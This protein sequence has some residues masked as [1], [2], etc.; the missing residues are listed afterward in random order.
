MTGSIPLNP[1]ADDLRELLSERYNF[2]ISWTDLAIVFSNGL[3]G[4]VDGPARQL[5]TIRDPSSSIV[6]LP[7]TSISN[8]TQAA[9]TINEV[10]TIPV[11]STITI[12]NLIQNGWTTLNNSSINV[13]SS[14]ISGD[15]TL[16]TINFDTSSFPA[17]G[18][19]PNAILLFYS[20]IT[21]VKN[22]CKML[23][24][25][26]DNNLLANEEWL[27]I[28]E[29]VA[30]HWPEKGTD[31]FAD[32]IG[33]IKNVVFTKMQLWT[34]DY[35]TFVDISKVPDNENTMNYRYYVP[36]HYYPTA[37]CGLEYNA[38]I[39]HP[40]PD[41]NDIRNLFYKLAPIHLVLAWIAG[42]F[43]AP[44]A[45][46]YYAMVGESE[47]IF[48]SNTY[49]TFT[50]PNLV[51]YK[52]V[53]LEGSTSLYNFPTMSNGTSFS[54]SVW[55]PNPNGSSIASE[56]SYIIGSPYGDYWTQQFYIFTR[57]YAM[58][59]IVLSFIWNNT[60]TNFGG[61]TGSPFFLVY[62]SADITS[63]QNWVN[64]L[65]SGYIDNSNI[66]HV[67]MWL[68]DTEIALYWVDS[69]N[70]EQPMPPPALPTGTQ[71][72]FAIAQNGN[73]HWEVGGESRD[74]VPDQSG[75][76]GYYGCMAE[77]WFAANQYIDFTIAA[78]RRL[79]NQLVNGIYQP[80]SL[81]NDG[82]TPL[83]G[84]KPTLYLSGDKTTFFTNKA[85]G[86]NLSEYGVLQDCTT[87]MG[88]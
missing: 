36:G 68:N 61:V 40:E 28:A 26:Y 67:T 79:F 47:A 59:G 14:S 87:P 24:L 29:H 57:G 83:N 64:V 34:Q 30:Q 39:F 73:G 27:R 70:V 74:E 17:Y 8:A 38:L 32:F 49:T 88:T 6:N 5:A 15:Y 62:N 44:S 13:V 81:G 33:Y 75:W 53:N 54:F 76:L 43:N 80:V 60:G 35:K 55:I 41:D 1:G 71:F 37:H 58:N 65:V 72:P 50:T 11:N 77:L 7:I 21:N 46:Q 19:N 25:S 86:I 9:V 18:N 84:A 52:A 3:D 63:N 82:S 69:N 51:V 45:I 4:F 78:N 48:N 42:Y 56:Y 2:E 85:N 23:G 12:K 31:Y 22:I 10:I 16:V 66:L 20:G